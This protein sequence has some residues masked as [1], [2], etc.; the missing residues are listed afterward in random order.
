MRALVNALCSVE[1][2]QCPIRAGVEY[3]DPMPS[4]LEISEIRSSRM[5]VDRIDQAYPLVRELRDDLT[6]EAWRVYAQSFFVLRPI[7]EGHCGIVVAEHRGYIRGLLSYNI[8]PDLI[9]RKTMVVRD[10]IVPLLPAS[11]PAARSLLQEVFSIAEAHHCGQARIELSEG[12]GWLAREWSD[13][14]GQLF[15]FPVICIFTNPAIQLHE[16]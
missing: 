1:V 14:Q 7:E 11:Q 13:P 15:R 5:S 6:L 10:V 3:G 8:L 16:R 4:S 2:Y 9:E 12:M